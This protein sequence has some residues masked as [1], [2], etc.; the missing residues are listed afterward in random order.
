MTKRQLQLMVDN[1]KLILHALWLAESWE[2]SCAACTT[3]ELTQHDPE[4]L[5]Q[6]ADYQASAQRF[7]TLRQ[8]LLTKSLP[9]K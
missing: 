8:Q 4:L 9:T 7:R 3:S 6:Q 1:H 5:K 2:E